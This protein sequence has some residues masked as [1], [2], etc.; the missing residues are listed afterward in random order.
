MRSL[1]KVKFNVHLLIPS[2]IPFI[3]CHFVAIFLLNCNSGVQELTLVWHK[4]RRVGYNK[5]H[6]YYN[7]GTIIIDFHKFTNIGR[8]VCR[9]I[10][11]G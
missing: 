4:T 10:Y 2:G 6:F 8:T 7:L 9:C 3:L 11:R 5:T 1:V